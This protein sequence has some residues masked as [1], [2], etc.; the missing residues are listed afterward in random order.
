M[1]NDGQI[2]ERIDAFYRII[3][4]RAGQERNW[5][6]FRTLFYPDARLTPNQRNTNNQFCAVAYDVEK[7][8]ARLSGFLG[9][10]DFYEVG[11]IQR[12]EVYGDIAQVYST[13][14]AR[15]TETSDEILKTGVCLVQFIYCSEGWKIISMVWE[16][17]SRGS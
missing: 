15:V 10:N 16:D 6:Q 7:Y 3:S 11:F 9:Q 14:E 4:G 2:Q 1:K 17:D 12:V 5:E 8:I 13:Y